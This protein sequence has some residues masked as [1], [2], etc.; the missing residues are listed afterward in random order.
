[1]DESRKTNRIRGPR[2]AEQ[3]LAGVVIDIG[4]GRDPVC[5]GAEPFDMP[6]GDAAQIASLRPNDHYDTV[7]SSHCL[8]HMPDPVAAIHQWWK[9]VKPG[10]YL[11]VVVPDENL[12]EQGFWPSRFNS[13]H[14]ATFR[15]G[16]TQSWSPVSHDIEELVK[17]LPGAD[18]IDAV[19]HDHHYDYALQVMPGQKKFRKPW[20]PVRFVR[21][22]LRAITKPL[23]KQ[24]RQEKIRSF[25][26][27]CCRQF[28][29]PVDQTSREALAQIQVIARKKL[30]HP[31]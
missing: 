5:P 1:M 18:L 19:R 9:L 23:G 26:D 3:Y 16:G 21:K 6:H 29:I 11:I 27:Y 30:A 15:L 14:K 24:M 8:E 12:Y 28:G 10:G 17:S 22:L 13:D 4:C 20:F 31:A 25:E 2:F 7:H